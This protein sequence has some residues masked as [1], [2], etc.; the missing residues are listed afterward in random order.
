[1]LGVIVEAAECGCGQGGRGRQSERRHTTAFALERVSTEIEDRAIGAGIE[2]IA[3][4]VAG[5]AIGGLAVDLFGW[6]TK[7]SI[8]HETAVW[9]TRGPPLPDVEDG[10]GG[11]VIA[12]PV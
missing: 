6:R 3:S 11:V 5:G 7:I 10:A 8:L 12:A 4:G 1:M 2:P 9:R